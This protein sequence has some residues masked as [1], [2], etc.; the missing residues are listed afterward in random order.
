[1]CQ[2]PSGSNTKVLTNT[3]CESTPRDPAAVTMPAFADCLHTEEIL[4]HAVDVRLLHPGQ[5]GPA[6]AQCKQIEH[7]IVIVT[8]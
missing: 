5:W 2:E 7:D 6:A 8:M 1:M 4:E 3:G